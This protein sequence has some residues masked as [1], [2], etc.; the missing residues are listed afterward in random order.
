MERLIKKVQVFKLWQARDADRCLSQPPEANPEAN[1]GMA[2][3][4][5][6][7]VAGGCSAATCA[8]AVAATTISSIPALI[9]PVFTPFRDIAMHVV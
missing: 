3:G 1:A 6:V 7:V 8:I 9:T 2:V 5:L 4:L